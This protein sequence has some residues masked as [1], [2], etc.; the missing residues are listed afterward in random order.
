MTTSV[1]K[2][3][4]TLWACSVLVFENCYHYMNLVFFENKKKGNKTCSSC[5]TC[6]LEQKTTFENMNL[7]SN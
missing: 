4:E 5:F 6:F 2:I 3:F 1:K 7:K